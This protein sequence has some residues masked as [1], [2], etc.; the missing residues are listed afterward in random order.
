M[1]ETTSTDG[2]F[3][4]NAAEI[5]EDAAF[6]PLPDPLIQAEVFKAH[7]HGNDYLVV[8]EGGAIRLTPDL[9]GR[10]CHRW[11]GLGSDG[12]VTVGRGSGTSRDPI[13][14]RM[15]NP[16]GSEFE[17]SGN[18][19]R[20]AAAFLYEE[21]QIATDPFVVTVG[22][23]TVGLHVVSE[24]APGVLDVVATMGRVTF[25]V[26][27]P[28]V[29]QG[30]PF[31][32]G[33]IH[34]PVTDPTGAEGVVAAM[35]VSVGN[36]H[37][38]LLRDSWSERD[39]ECYGPQIASHPSFPEGTNVQ[40]ASVGNMATGE[41]SPLPI[42]IWERGVGRTTSSGTSACAAASAA[43]KHGILGPGEL[44]VAMEGG[45]FLVQVDPE[46]EVRLRGPVE[47]LYT[48]QM[49]GPLTKASSGRDR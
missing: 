44:T 16:D 1:R 38:V 6:V 15:F 33:L 12:I 20:V 37:A 34:L 29:R 5:E 49:R 19:L 4:V 11:R 36:P 30:T 42:F 8:R 9:I 14:L 25:P 39:L 23:D 17:R 10:I 13:P 28:F 48:A 46:F 41:S 7:G 26:G 32:D 31:T 3:P 22:G 27:P 40:F 45:A 21:G 2:G 35:A 43:V 18:G 24:S 47:V